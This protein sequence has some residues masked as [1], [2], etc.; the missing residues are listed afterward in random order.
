MADACQNG[1][2]QEVIRNGRKPGIVPPLPPFKIDKSL[3]IQVM[4]C[5]LIVA[6]HASIY[7]IMA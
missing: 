1:E 3:I 5:C 2:L 6:I 7:V 4:L